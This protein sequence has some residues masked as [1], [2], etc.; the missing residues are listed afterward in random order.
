MLFFVAFANCLADDPSFSWDSERSSK[1]G[2]P[3]LNVIFPD[4]QKDV[5]HLKNSEL[6]FLLP[7][8]REDLCLLNGYLHN[9]PS[10]YVVVNGGCA[11]S[12]TFDASIFLRIIVGNPGERIMLRFKPFLSFQGIEFV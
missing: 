10:S 7:E 1:N 8:T 6:S 3:L 5:I 11:F 12:D 4:G 2:I 9:E